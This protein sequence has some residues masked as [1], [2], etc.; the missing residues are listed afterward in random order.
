MVVVED[1]VIEDVGSLLTSCWEEDLELFES[2][3]IIF[4]PEQRL[5]LAVIIRALSDYQEWFPRPKSEELRRW[6][7]AKNHIEAEGTFMFYL[8]CAFINAS[9]DAIEDMA[10]DIRKYVLTLE[11]AMG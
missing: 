4:Q 2:P 7:F 9:R 11:E 3:I 10:R 1:D 6:F 5:A 8:Q